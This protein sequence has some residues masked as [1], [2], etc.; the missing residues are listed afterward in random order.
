MRWCIGRGAAKQI[1][2]AA[3]IESTAGPYGPPEGS[4]LREL[5]GSSTMSA[6]EGARGSLGGQSPRSIALLL[7][8]NISLSLSHTNTL[9]AAVRPCC[10]LVAVV[11]HSQPQGA[12]V[13]VLPNGV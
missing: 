1:G 9:I 13:K 10:A 12:C 6:A 2:R 4:N 8:P 5:P 7:I 11:A 3:V